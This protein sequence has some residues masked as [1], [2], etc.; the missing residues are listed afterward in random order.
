M[1][2]KVKLTTTKDEIILTVRDASTKEIL[3]DLNAKEGR[4]KRIYSRG[5]IRTIVTGRYLSAMEK[6]KI[7]RILRGIS[8]DAEIEFIDDYQKKISEKEDDEE[9]EVEDTEVAKQRIVN[10]SGSLGLHAIK[11]TFES[12]I[13]TSQTKF[14]HGNLR[15]GQREEFVGS[16][17]GLGDLNYGAEVVA[18]ENIIVTGT[19][20]GLAHAG[21]NGN[22]K[23][24][25]AGNAINCTQIR[26]ANIVKEVRNTDGKFPFVYLENDDII[27]ELSS[28]KGVNE[29]ENSKR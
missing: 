18:G 8:T 4:L 13:E 15:S 21:A 14:I 11:S 6:E 1:R 17:V 20:R 2:A 3:Y 10:T 25:I 9:E 28:I 29:L 19:I 16:L 24:I 26:I 7:K 5:Y 23:A 22:K 27:I 12:E